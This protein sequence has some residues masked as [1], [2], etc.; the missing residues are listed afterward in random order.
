MWVI[1]DADYDGDIYFE[2][3]GTCWLG[4]DPKFDEFGKYELEG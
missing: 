4:P 2:I 1:G 3:Y